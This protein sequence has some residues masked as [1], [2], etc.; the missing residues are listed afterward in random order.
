MYSLLLECWFSQTFPV[1]NA[2]EICVH[3]YS[4]FYAYYSSLYRKSWVL[5]NTFNSQPNITCLS[6][7]FSCS[8]LKLSFLTVRNITPIALKYLVTALPTNPQ[9]PSS[10]CLGSDTCARSHPCT[11]APLIHYGFTPPHPALSYS[12][13]Q[14]SFSPLG[15][16][17]LLWTTA[18]SSLHLINFSLKCSGKKERKEEL[19]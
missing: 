9:T 19:W 4:C 10:S 15:V 14:M 1:D 18:S 6:L 2:R 12:P 17:A 8:Y 3:I 7:V 13:M 11:D 5:T 16:Q